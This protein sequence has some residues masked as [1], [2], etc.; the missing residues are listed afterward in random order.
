MNKLLIVLASLLFLVA[1]GDDNVTENQPIVDDI[2]L[3]KNDTSDNFEITEE[4][5]QVRNEF[6]EVFNHY[7]DDPNFKGT[8][9]NI[10]N[11]QEPSKEND[12]YW[13]DI[14][15]DGAEI[16]TKYDEKGNL[17]GY[18]VAFDK[19]SDNGMVYASIIAKTLGLEIS[20]FTDN[21]RAVLETEEKIKTKT[22]NEFEY[23]ISISE[24]TDAGFLII[25]FD[26]E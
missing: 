12:S 9:I 8:L 2:K 25:N 4:S 13:Q 10:K 19:K 6:I 3:T 11:I 7:A 23:Q 16:K 17:T 18:H 26:K 14:H 20:N 5:I 21:V 1:C 24:F 15:S 22:Y